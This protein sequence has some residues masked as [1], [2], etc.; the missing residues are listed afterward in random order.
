M[1]KICVKVD[2][3]RN[4]QRKGGG[5]GCGKGRHFNWDEINRT[6]RRDADRS[7]N[8]IMRQKERQR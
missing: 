1:N 8:K 5:G 7:L 4:L 2:N 6:R 3:K